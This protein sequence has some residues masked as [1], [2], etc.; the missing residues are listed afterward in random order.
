MRSLVKQEAVSIL[1]LVEVV[2][3][4][5][6][7]VEVVE[8]VVVEVVVEVVVVE[9][10]VVVVEVVVEEEEEEGRHVWSALMVSAQRASATSPGSGHLSLHL[11]SPVA[12]FFIHILSVFHVDRLVELK[13]MYIKRVFR[14]RAFGENSPVSEN[15]KD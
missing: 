9:V 7:V 4:E 15:G 12:V 3:V 10:V 8:V 2:V 13:D 11:V 1:M 14:A 5:V 6:V